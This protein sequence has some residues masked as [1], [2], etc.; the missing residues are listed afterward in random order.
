MSARKLAI[1]AGE[2]SG[3]ALGAKLM[4]ALRAGAGQDIA[5]V[6]V[7]GSAMAGQGLESFFPLGD[8]HVMGISAVLARLPLILRRIRETAERIVAE[9]PDGLIIIDSPDFTHRVAMRVRKALPGLKVVDYVSPS[10]WAWRP[11]RARAMRAYVDRVLA[12]L[13][14][15]PAAHRRLGGPDCVYVGHPLT[16]RLAELRPSAAE[17]ARRG[18]KPPLVL[19]LPGSRRSEIERLMSPFGEALA[20]LSKRVGPFDLALPTLPHV[21]ALARSQSA[22]WPVLPRIV[23]GEAEKFALFRSAR[24]ALA[25]SGTVTLELALAGVPHVGAYRVSGLELLV[26][27]FVSTTSFLLPNLV[28]GEKAIPELMQEDCTPDRLAGALAPLIGDGPERAAQVGALARLDAL[29]ALPD[30]QAPSAAAARAAMEV[31]GW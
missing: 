11:G 29:M 5:F 8:I 24:A 25:A 3:D 16:E 6:G 1:V 30:G 4:A 27:P 15:E 13:P 14:F 23:L 19:V 12:L 21:E 9:R 28:L 7:G 20:M 2:S 31:L 18:A 26:R 17:A 22:H 10:V